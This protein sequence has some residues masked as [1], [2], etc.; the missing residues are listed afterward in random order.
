M[1]RTLT[2]VLA[3]LLLPPLLLAL[4]G[5]VYT[6]DYDIPAGSPGRHVTVN[7]L[8]L[9]VH[10]AGAGR[11]VVFLHGGMGSLEDWAPVFDAP[12]AREAFRMTAFDRPGMGY[13]ELVGEAYSLNGAA[14]VTLALIERLGL[15]D[16]IL[17]GHSYGGGVALA[18]AVQDDP[19]VSAVL[20]IAPAAYDLDEVYK[21][22]ETLVT[23]LL[24]V[25]LIGRGLAWSAGPLLGA[26]MIAAVLEPMTKGRP[27]FDRSF[28][29]F[30]QRLWN[31]AISTTTRA[32]QAAAFMRDMPGIS[33][34]YPEIRVPVTLMIGEDDLPE[35][36]DMVAPLQTDVPRLRVRR[37][38]GVE[39]YLQFEA[40]QAV[41]TEL[42]SLARE[43]Q[44]AP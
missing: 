15:R 29:S 30:R 26:D 6:P 24:R 40:P 32:H 44:P 28:I 5:L 14:R 16:V 35:L 18:T 12:G 7:D 11:D 1:K 22:Q 9:R 41:V 3:L 27:A 34:R 2:I 13:S 42:E 39:H 43:T 17:V 38:P 31:K 25:P 19:A 21:K 4:A 33:A 20:L 10:Q 36:L 37:L 8:R 23:R